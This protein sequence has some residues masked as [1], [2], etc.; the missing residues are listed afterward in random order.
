MLNWELVYLEK[1]WNLKVPGFPGGCTL[2]DIS[3]A[4]PTIQRSENSKN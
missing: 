3:P 1:S 2:L 4:N